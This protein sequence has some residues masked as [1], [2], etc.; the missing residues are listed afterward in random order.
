MAAATAA[1]AAAT[2]AATSAAPVTRPPTTIDGEVMI[3]LT[4]EQL[5]S[6]SMAMKLAPAM[7]RVAAV[8]KFPGSVPPYHLAAGS[9]AL[10][11]LP[12][13]LTNNYPTIHDDTA[14]LRDL[15]SDRKSVV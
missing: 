2:A 8:H 9:T 15:W 4:L 12:R 3:A 10:L 6:I 5:R 14:R 13:W 1:A 11:P 7:G